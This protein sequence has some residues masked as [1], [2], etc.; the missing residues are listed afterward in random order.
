MASDERFVFPSLVEG[1][2]KGI[3]ERFSPE[4][5]Q[6]LKSAGLDVAKLPPAIPVHEMERYMDL[7]SSH[8]WPTVTREEQMRLLGLSA[9]RGWQS[10]LLG[11]A[12][13]AMLRVLGPRRTLTRLDRA[14]ST[15][16]NFN[17][18]TTQF[19]DDK[20]ALITVNDVQDRPTYWVGIFQAGLEILGLDGVVT[21][22]AQ[23][24][25]SATFRVKWK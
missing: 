17:K 22:D 7:I 5:K 14:F 9:I 25:P 23:Q 8:A 15:T 24:A 3:G 12:T 6:K 21:I 16:N 2:M 13:S 18:A 19:V 1:Y 20:E 11:S 4:L 10:G